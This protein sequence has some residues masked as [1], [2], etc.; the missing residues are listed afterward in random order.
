[1]IDRKLCLRHGQTAVAMSG[2][3]RFIRI[4]SANKPISVGLLE[5]FRYLSPF[6]GG[7]SLFKVST[8]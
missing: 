7:M 5:V 1:M 4:D 8:I 2:I 6:Q 3:H